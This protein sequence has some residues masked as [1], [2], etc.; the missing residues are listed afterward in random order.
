M[1]GQAYFELSQKIEAAH[2]F[3]AVSSLLCDGMPH[4][5]G[6][7]SVLVLETGEGPVIRGVHG[8]C[9][10]A[11]TTRKRID[12]LNGLLVDHPLIQRVDLNDPGA[13][14]AAVSDFI[15]PEEYQANEFNRVMHDGSPSTDGI[16]GKLVASPHS[17]TILVSCRDE[18]MFSLKQRE[19]FDAVLFTARAVLGR[20]GSMGVETTVRNFLM[21]TA[22]DPIAVFAV[23]TDLEVL[24]LSHEAVRLSEN[25]WSE[26]EAKRSLSPESHENLREVLENAWTDPV[27]ATFQEVELDLGGG[28]RKCHAL[29]KASGEILIFMPV[30]GHLPSG[31]EAL[32][33]VL[34]KRQREIMEWIAEGKTSAEAAIIL[35]ISP[36]TVEKH[37]EAVFQRLGVENRISAVRRF[38]DLK[39]GQAT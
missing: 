16:L 35:D 34:T 13:L 5:V 39:S 24:P 38:L 32:K 4:L 31:D 21:G 1:L 33:A 25:W 6:A 37:L 23:G 10:V 28:L 17:T 18:G 14:G 29:P 19:I 26:D 2:S 7:D 3:A 36:R 15:S 12:E 9:K 20:I 11:D 22:G 27:K 30:S 8:K